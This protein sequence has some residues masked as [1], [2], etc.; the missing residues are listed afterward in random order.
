MIDTSTYSDKELAQHF[1][2]LELQI[3][4]LVIKNIFNE[5]EV[6]NKLNDIFINLDE[7]LQ[8]EQ[9]RGFFLYHRYN[10]QFSFQ[11]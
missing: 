9:G 1:E 10:S 3:G 11:L 8:T 7:I 4:L 6:I 5:Q 2:S